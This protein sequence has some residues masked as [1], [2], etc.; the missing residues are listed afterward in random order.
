MSEM[1]ERISRKL[2]EMAIRQR[3]RFDTDPARLEEML[4]AMVDMHWTEWKGEARAALEAMREPTEDMAER[5][6]YAIAAEPGSS[7]DS[8]ESAKR[9]WQTMID[10]ALQGA[11]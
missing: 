5:G 1:V 6:C 2:V 4:P 9:C 7:A 11:A 8:A 3:R 10:K